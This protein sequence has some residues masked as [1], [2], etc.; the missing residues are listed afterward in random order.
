MREHAPAFT[1]SRKTHKSRF[2]RGRGQVWPPEMIL[3]FI[4]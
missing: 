1:V 4:L 3:S 2:A